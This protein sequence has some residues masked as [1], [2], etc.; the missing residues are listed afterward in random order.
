MEI[1][2]MII[3]GLALTLIL[4]YSLMQ[5]S[6]VIN[7]LKYKKRKREIPQSVLN[8]KGRLPLVTIQLPVYNEKYVVE[9]LLDAVSKFDYPQERMEI[10]VL[11][12]STD[13]TVEI[14]SKKVNELRE[15]GFDIEL[16]YRK[17]RIGF[18][19]G[20]LDEGLQKAKGK[21]IAIF[22]A[23]FIPDPDFLLRTLPY[24]GNDK[25][26]V[27]QTRWGHINRNYSLLTRLQAFGL[28][29]HFS[30]EQGGRNQGGHFINFNGTAGVWRRTTIDD[31]GGWEHDTL[32]EDLDLSYRA[33]MNGWKFVF[34]EEVETPAEL[35]IVMSAVKS[36]QFRWNKGGAENFRKMLGRIFST[37]G[38]PFKTRM[39]G[40]FH[41]LN[42]A[43]FLC[44]LTAA[45]L[46]VPLLF[47]KNAHPEYN[48]IFDIS[49]IFLLCTIILMVFYW[50][51]YREKTSTFFVNAANF[52]RE[53]ILFL[54]TTMGLSFHNSVAVIEG[55]LG[56]KSSF[57]R[58]PKFNVITPGQKIAQNHY[59][60]KSI[61][62]VS[63]VEGVLCLY[64]LF[65][66]AS[67]IILQEYGL[68]PFHLMLSWGFG[69]VFYYSLKN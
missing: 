49:S 68:L 65:G 3:Y 66:I 20:A 24:L 30:V 5:M 55:Y 62:L 21:Y 29:A 28:D 16:L 4:F 51:A 32:T 23:D 8:G 1:A 40:F 33:Q 54:A 25:V 44:V 17:N 9:R 69:Y 19:A 7:Y 22:D 53:F 18:K 34:L 52:L 60:S 43:I 13:E 14:S 12:D 47:I 50:N 26:G 10:Q 58:T 41:L 61:N 63:F 2:I 42:S 46:S 15:Q 48:M 35:P 39:H 27:V 57:V 45:L 31:A 56:K 64:F 11:D 38:I 36:Q 37:P 59:L 67:G 6:L